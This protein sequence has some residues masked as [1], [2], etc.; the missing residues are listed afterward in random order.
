MTGIT[1]FFLDVPYVS[2]IARE[3]QTVQKKYR[4]KKNVCFGCPHVVGQSNPFILL[5][6][7]I[8][9]SPDSVLRRTKCKGESIASGGVET[10]KATILDI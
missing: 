6:H 4:D 10:I 7:A 3:C 2:N 5:R 1:T 8:F 9:T